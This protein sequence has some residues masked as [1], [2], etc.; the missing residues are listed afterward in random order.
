MPG[1]GKTFCLAILVKIFIE[2]DSQVLVTSYTHSALDN[3][4]RKF[5][6]I[7]GETITFNNIV[8]FGISSIQSIHSQNHRYVYDVST[9]KNV[10]QID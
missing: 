4:I 6:E 9:F 5:E 7:F 2:L 3:I 10:A 8:R 1:T